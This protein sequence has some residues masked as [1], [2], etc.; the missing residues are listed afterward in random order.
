MYLASFRR[1]FIK[2]AFWSDLVNWFDGGSTP[3]KF[4]V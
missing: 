3:P 1:K 4:E 2:T